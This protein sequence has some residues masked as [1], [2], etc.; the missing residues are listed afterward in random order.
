AT[1]SVDDQKRVMTPGEAVRAGA[2]YLVIGRPISAAADP[3]A[4]VAAI[5]EEIVSA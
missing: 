3:V 5:V 4:A 1:A 2:D